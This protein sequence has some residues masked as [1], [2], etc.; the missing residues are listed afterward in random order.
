MGRGGKRTGSGRP[1]SWQNRK[2]K[3]IRVPEKFADELLDIARQMDAGCFNGSA[4]IL[5]L[6]GVQV[7]H[8]NGEIAVRLEDVVKK[9]YRVSPP[10]LAQMVNSRIKRK[11]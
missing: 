11:N 9:G 5:D 7:T 10:L 2:T 1:S 3:L 8:A 4:H 6:T